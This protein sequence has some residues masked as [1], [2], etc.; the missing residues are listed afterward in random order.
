MFCLALVTSIPVRVAGENYALSTNPGRIQESNV[1]GVAL[2]LTV[3]GAVPSQAYAFVWS[4]RD[5]SGACCKTATNSTP[6]GGPGQSSF[7]LSVVYPRDFGGGASVQFVGIYSVSVQQTTP[8]VGPPV[9]AG[10][11]TVGLTD[12]LS[13]QRTS[14]VSIVAQ[15]YGGGEV[16]TVNI[17]RGG[18]PVTGFPV[19]KPTD[20]SGR[21]S[22]LWSGIPPS[23][24]LGNYTVTVSGITVKAVPDTQTITI[25]PATITIPQLTIGQNTLQR[26]QTQEF[27]FT[28]NYPNPNGLPVQS[29]TAALRLTEADGTTSHSATASYNSTLTSFR[30]TYRVSLSGQVGIWVGAIDPGSFDDGFGN[31]GPAASVARGFSVQPASLTVNVSVDNKTYTAGDLVIIH[32]S[33]TSPDGSLFSAGSVTASLS[34][35]GSQIGTSVPL[36]YIQ[37]QGR[38]VGSYTV[39]ATNPSGL[40]LIQASASDAYG[41]SGQAS[42]SAITNIPTQQGTIPTYWFVL[43][44]ALLGGVIG[45]V[46]FFFKRRGTFRRELQVD[47]KAVG[48]EAERIENQEFFKSIQ[49][50]LKRKPEDG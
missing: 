19:S 8:P 32:A 36:S 42:A 5:S 35:S 4:V 43:A 41:N 6:L 44:L 50:Q 10:Q 33:V 46:L 7:S 28:A 9:A 2:G 48:L 14:S 38:W 18:T 30:G 49:D 31:T 37:S 29:G 20:A 24:A 22:Y 25:Y 15:G 12:S 26:T 27:R 1:P 13:Y 47:L 3:S 17:A 16:V 40:W 21:L 34:R 39:N 45:L 23:I 11:F